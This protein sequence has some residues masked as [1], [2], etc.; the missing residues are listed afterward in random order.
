MQTQPADRPVSLCHHKKTKISKWDKCV[1]CRECGKVLTPPPMIMSWKSQQRQVSQQRYKRLTRFREIVRA[2]K[3]ELQSELPRSVREYVAAQC[4]AR[5][6]LTPTPPQV[7]S[8]LSRKRWK[9]K[10]GPQ[11]VAIATEITGDQRYVL[12]LSRDETRML[13]VLFKRVDRVWP[14]VIEHLHNKLGWVR[15]TFFNYGWLLAWL[16]HRAGYVERSKWAMANIALRTLELKHR[17]E[18]LMLTTCHFLEWETDF[19]EGN[20]LSGGKKRMPKAPHLR[21]GGGEYKQA[22]RQRVGKTNS[23]RTPRL[24]FLPVV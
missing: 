5:G 7:C 22:K 6:W 15:K 16:L 9:S 10:Y 2:A 12:K 17:Q 20:L 11:A 21:F 3:G 13:E 14:K 4:K 18:Y 1:V 24:K 8:I 23:G 19:L